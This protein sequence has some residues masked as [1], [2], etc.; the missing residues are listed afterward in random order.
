MESLSPPTEEVAS[1]LPPIAARLCAAARKILSDRGFGDLTIDA[2]AREAGEYKAS[3]AYYFGNKSGLLAAVADSVYP[4]DL[5][6]ATVAEA[7]KHQP[8]EERVRAQMA[9]L[10]RMADDRD[11]IRAFWELLPHILRDEQ[12]RSDLSAVYDW[13]RRLDVRM[14]GVDSDDHE[15]L[16]YAGAL[17]VAAV[18]GFALQ[19]SLDPEGFDLEKAFAML[20][21]MV[22]SFVQSLQRGDGVA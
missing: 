5:C 2:V 1:T 16:M 21:R 22:T 7:E 17:V 10:L 19:A 8:G 14:F 20:E 4:R 15:E 18:D 3:V 13:Y 9:G 6:M 11:S 12:L